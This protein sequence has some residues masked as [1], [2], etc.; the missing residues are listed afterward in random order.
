[1][2]SLEQKKIAIPEQHT[3]LHEELAAYEYTIRGGGKVSYDA[4]AGMHDDLPIALMLALWGKRY[5]S[6]AA[7]MGALVMD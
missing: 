4:P 3:A 7:G 2:L 6:T 5:V 1:M